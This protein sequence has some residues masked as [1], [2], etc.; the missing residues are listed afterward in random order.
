MRINR[1]VIKNFR[2]YYGESE[3]VFNNEGKVTLIYGRSGYGKSSILQFFRWVLY[4]NPD[5]GE[6]NDKPFYNY[7]L[8]EEKS[9]GESFE[10]LGTIDFEH[11]GV[12]YS[13]TK[14]IVYEKN[15]TSIN[16]IE[17]TCELSVLENNAWIPFT[18]DV[19]NKINSILPKELS[20]YFFLDGEK[21]R[22]TVLDSKDLKKAIHLLFGLDAYENFIKH[23][24][25]KGKK[26]SVIG[27]YSNVLSS[28]VTKTFKDMSASEMQE[29]LDA[30]GEEIEDAREE[31]K[32][33]VTNINELSA[34]RDEL[35]KTLGE[36]SNKPYIVNN[37]KTN[38]TLIKELSEKIVDRQTEIGSL[39]YKNYPYL[40][41]SKLV[42]N[43]LNLLKKQKDLF[44]KNYKNTFENLTKSL[45]KEIENRGVC[46]CGRPL[47]EQ[48]SQHISRILISMPPSLTYI[49]SQF[50]LKSKGKI[51][52]SKSEIYKYAEIINSISSYQQRI[53]D[54]EQKIKESEAEL[55]KL[56]AMKDSIMH[57]DKIKAQIVE[58]EKKKGKLD[59]DI[60]RMKNIYDLSLR[61][62]ETLQKNDRY[63]QKYNK[64][65]SF[66]QEMLEEITYEKEDY[67]AEIKDTLNKCVRST[68][69]KLTTQKDLDADKI[70][71]IQDD[72]S[73]RIT[74]LTGGQLQV[75]VYSY[76]VGIT[77]TL[78]KLGLENN[79]NPIVVDAPFAFT[80]EIQSEHIFSTLPQIAKQVIFMTLDLNKIENILK[81]DKNSYELYLIENAS[82]NKATINRGDF[83]DIKR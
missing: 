54:L 41:L 24:G 8:A 12:K 78:Q 23:I 7:V 30:L 9:D 18:G 38:E 70:K 1:L 32:A 6:H 67:E 2:C 37:I 26:K 21:S 14:R 73:L 61:Q 39:F 40:L 55:E 59:G 42:M 65:I 22:E 46:V 71:F 44:D 75:D 60:S 83:N 77:Q 10:V 69:K 31:R 62:L 35:L 72:F 81:N 17:S 28:K 19:P 79:E 16:K 49:Y 45:L 20:K 82:Q 68:F 56:N 51:S 15:N 58:L 52:S 3:I 25:S 29:E 53:S 48:S 80:D 33:V 27:Y 63:S 74:F 47:D 4:D 76:I 13:I 5:F 66:L 11:I 36:L 50:I 43:N 64:I 57:L 34:Q